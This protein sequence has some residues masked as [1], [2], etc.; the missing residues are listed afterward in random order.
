MKKLFVLAI[1]LLMLPFA[2]AYGVTFYSPKQ[3]PQY[4]KAFELVEPDTPYTIENTKDKD[5][6]VTKITFTINREAKTAGITVYHLLYP[7]ETLPPVPANDSYELNELKYSGFVPHDTTK[8]VYEFKVKKDWLE[9]NSV[10]RN[11]VVLHAYNRRTDHWDALPTKILSDDEWFVYFSAEGVG[12]H[13]LFIGKS[14]S[15]TTAESVKSDVEDIEK[16]EGTGAE[17]KD[18]PDMTADITPIQLGDTTPSVPPAPTPTP[19]TVEEKEDKSDSTMLSALILVVLAV[20]IIIIYL[21]FGKRKLGSSVDKELNKYIDESLKRGKS[22]EDVRQ[23][24]LDVGWHHER[25][26]KAL[27][28]HKEPGQKPAGPVPAAKPKKPA[29]SKPAKKAKKK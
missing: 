25:V 7:P 8:L 4:G 12:Y 20:I 10:P 3:N 19:I 16:K 6:A 18:A 28:K 24:L 11:S 14:Q 5:V 9:N 26:E 13:Y 21:V 17:L 15:D 23:R 29:K 27:T 22:K 2:A 1:I